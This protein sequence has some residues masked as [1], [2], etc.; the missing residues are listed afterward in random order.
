MKNKNTEGDSWGQLLSDFGIEDQRQE[1]P[2]LSEEPKAVEPDDFGAGLTDSK[3]ETATESPKPKEKKSILSR[4]PK[5]NFFGTPPDVSLD[6]VIEGTKSPSLGGKTFTDNKLEKMPVSQERT[7]RRKKGF[8]EKEAIKE[9]SAWSTVA[10]QIDVLASGQDE[11]SKPGERPAR[12]AVV[13]MFDEPVPESEEFRAAKNLMEEQPRRDE[14]HREAFF[15]EEASSRQRGRGRRSP[16]PE[17]RETRG[18][19]SRYKPPVEVDD[20]PEPDFEPVD[21]EPPRTRGR[22]RRG[23]RYDNG[24]YREREPI[25]IQDEVQQ[26]EW[27][28][29]DVALQEGRGGRQQRNDKR[30]RPER[31]E[32]TARPVRD[33]ESVS[34]DNDSGTVAFLGDVPSWDEAIGDIISGNISRHKSHSSSER[35]S[36]GRGRR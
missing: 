13:S 10:S 2:A 21:D 24:G 6:S 14:S 11:K 32:R 8:Q 19:G 27:S 23:S 29:V 31:P 9:P 17:E 7:D 5:I 25:Q 34:D 20:L 12:R 16:E 18:R 36:S 35:A 15:E 22:G 26:E 3:A 30:R 1:E 4:F 28:E 33:R